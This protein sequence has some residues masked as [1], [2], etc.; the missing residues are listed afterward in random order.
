MS[1]LWDCGYWLG[2]SH[3]VDSAQATREEHIH[4]V[5]G[6]LCSHE[7]RG[8]DYCPVN[9]PR[10][11]DRCCFCQPINVGQTFTRPCLRMLCKHWLFAFSLQSYYCAIPNGEN[12][13][14]LWPRARLR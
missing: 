8:L 11:Q 10:G 6:Q 1:H 9:L 4:I 12:L 7:R 3:H 14:G 5:D 2:E 13:P